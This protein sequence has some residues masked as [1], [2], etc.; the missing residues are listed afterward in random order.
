PKG[1]LTGVLIGTAAALGAAALTLNS[2]EV[3]ALRAAA[4]IGGEAIHL[5]LD[6]VSALFLELLSVIGGLGAVS[7]REYWSE[8]AL[9][10]SARAGRVWW[11]VLVLCLGLVLVSANGLHFLIA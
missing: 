4:R 11:S 2:G 10:R 7:G 1:W 9:P 3:W 8:R 6:A 5:R